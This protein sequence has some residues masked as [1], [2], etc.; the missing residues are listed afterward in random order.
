M[1]D[2]I[3]NTKRGFREVTNDNENIQK[4]RKIYT[5]DVG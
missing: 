2:Y 1:E 5:A 4:K 3:C